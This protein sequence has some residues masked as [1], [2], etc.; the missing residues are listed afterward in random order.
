MD[1][2]DPND[3]CGQH[4]FFVERVRVEKCTQYSKKLTESQYF[5]HHNLTQ[6]RQIGDAIARRVRVTNL[7]Q[8]R[9]FL[10]C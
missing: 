5:K 10:A 4:G 6:T 3:P 1:S 7:T 9:R 2:S 8:P